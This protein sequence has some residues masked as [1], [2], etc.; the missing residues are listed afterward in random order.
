METQRT[1]SVRAIGRVV[2]SSL[3]KDAAMLVL[4]KYPEM[5]AQM[6]RLGVERMLADFEGTKTAPPKWLD[7]L[8]KQQ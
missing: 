7:K 3:S 4:N 5:R 8:A 6:Q 1:A 2:T